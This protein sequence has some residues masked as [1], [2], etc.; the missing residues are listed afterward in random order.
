MGSGYRPIFDAFK[1]LA[2]DANQ[3]LLDKVPDIEDMDKVRGKAY[4]DIYN[5][6]NKELYCVTQMDIS[7]AEMWA[8]H[9]KIF[10][11]KYSS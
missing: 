1:S 9:C 10:I 2:S 3:Q 11:T 8:Q 7:G 4:N 5:K 6:K